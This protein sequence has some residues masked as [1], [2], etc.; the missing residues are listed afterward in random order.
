MFYFLFEFVPKY[1]PYLLQGALV[2]LELCFCSMAL[3]IGRAH[4]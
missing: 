1:L 4:V 3:E 2:T